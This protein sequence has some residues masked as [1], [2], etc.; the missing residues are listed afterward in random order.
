MPSKKIR[1][2][3]I[4]LIL[5]GAFCAR[6]SV[7]LI[8]SGGEIDDRDAYFMLGRNI[9]STGKF[10]DADG[11]FTAFRPVLY[12]TALAAVIKILGTS[13][14]GI[15]A[16]N[17][18]LGSISVFC[19]YLITKRLIGPAA[20]ALAAAAVAI[21]PYL[22]LISADVMSESL[23]IPLGLLVIYFVLAAD[24]RSKSGAVLAGVFLALLVLCRPEGIVF[25]VPALIGFLALKKSASVRRTSVIIFLCVLCGIYSVWAY[26]NYIRFNTFIPFTTHGGYT[27]FLGNNKSFY[28]SASRGRKWDDA[29]FESWTRMNDAGTVRMNELEKND[30]FYK[31]AKEFIRKN[32][33]RFFHLMW[34]KFLRFW[35]PYPHGVSGMIA[36]TSA[37]YTV[38]L[39]VL[40]IAGAV[41]LFIKRK[42]DFLII[43]IPIILIC[44]VHM[45]Y[46]SQIRFRVPLHQ[47]FVILSFCFIFRKSPGE[48]AFDA[49]SSQ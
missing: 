20:A 46:W 18:L 8:S 27:L 6:L 13:A 44:I 39:Y 10:I 41:V 38:L 14:V 9:A 1:V 26:R 15:F 2:L 19:V 49:G 23:F 22:V 42:R 32:P 4:V 37:A 36:G 48:G 43:I 12:P 45:I 5:V 47:L 34:L 21:E 7:S 25:I 29:A 28:E 30:Y 40:S 17:A 31:E 3:I 33:R 24:D 11:H 16:L 35:R